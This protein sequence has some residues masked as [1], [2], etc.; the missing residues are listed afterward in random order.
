MFVADGRFHLEAAMIQNPGLVSFRYDPYSKVLTREGYDIQAMA[1]ARWFVSF[2][3]LPS[4]VPITSPSPLNFDCLSTD[5]RKA[6]EAARSC[7]V[8]GVILGTLG[9]QGNTGQ[10][11]RITTLLR[12]RGYRAIPFL[13]AEISP[14]KLALVSEIDVLYSNL[15]LAITSCS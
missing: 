2:P 8:F 4:F 11:K 14:S 3:F 7:R 13:M 5:L 12:S 15:N 9:R 6:I 10:L 1:S